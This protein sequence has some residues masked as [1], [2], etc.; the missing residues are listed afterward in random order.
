MAVTKKSVNAKL[1]STSIDTD[2]ADRSANKCANNMRLFGLPYQFTSSV[3]PRYPGISSTVGRR[4]VDN[5]IMDAPTVYIIP[6]KPVFLPGK[7]DKKS[8][9]GALVSASN[10]KFKNFK[11]I[12]SDNPSEKLRYYDFESDYSEYIKYVNVM[13][14]AA[15]GFMEIHETINVKGKP[16]KFQQY[17][18]KNYRWTAPYYTSG[19][20][21]GT[22]N[23]FGKTVKKV[24][25]LVKDITS[26]FRGGKQDTTGEE[27]TIDDEVGII[28]G[29]QTSNFVQFYVDPSSSAH[30]DASNATSPSQLKSAMDT[31]SSQMKEFQ[32]IANS[33]GLDMSGLENFTDSSMSALSSFL[34]GNGGSSIGNILSRIVTAGSTVIK[35]ENIMIPEIYQN[36]DFNR[37]YSVTIHL[38]APYGN[39]FGI[40]MDVIVPLIH[41]IALVI[42]KQSTA[43]TYGSPFIIKAF[44]PGVFNCNLGIVTSIQIEKT[45]S[46][47]SWT[48]DGLPNE[49]DVT[50]QIKDLYSELTMSP[51]TDPHLFVCN[52][53]M[54]DYLSTICGLSLIQPQ[55]KTKAKMIIGTYINALKDTP[56]NIKSGIT[57]SME[58]QFSKWLY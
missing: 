35:G 4:F 20:V 6:G 51:S 39:K 47:D 44:F 24:K 28:E 31:A 13:C 12:L 49:V 41:L 57:D 40:Y 45:V 27:I 48:N 37:D 58:K 50:L 42:P 38:K 14:R 16:V 25:G 11:D 46:S 15:A 52:N 19:V 43:N 34:T 3:D 55:L 30:E 22:A 17:D 54:I 1:K 53:S 2:L 29:F 32:F 7:S 26:T 33:A 8:T 36:S 21:S 5:I 18:W 56:S 10:N 23:V 9:A